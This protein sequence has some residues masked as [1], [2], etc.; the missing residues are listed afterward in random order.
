MNEVFVIVVGTRLVGEVYFERSADAA[1]RVADV[2]DRV[3]RLGASAHV[4]TKRLLFDGRRHK[5]Q[6]VYVITVEGLLIDNACY[7]DRDALAERLADVQNQN[8][9]FS[10]R[11][12]VEVKRLDLATLVV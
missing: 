6:P 12:V 3:N 2:R 8:A 10:R 1:S 9:R 5:E 11:H 4:G 7:L